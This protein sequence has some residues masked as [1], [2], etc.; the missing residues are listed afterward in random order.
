MTRLIE[1]LR[2]P[3]LGFR[4]LVWWPVLCVLDKIRPVKVQ[5]AVGQTEGSNP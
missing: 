3:W 2:L 5:Q 4:M 1:E